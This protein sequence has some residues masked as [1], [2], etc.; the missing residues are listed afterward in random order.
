MNSVDR[1]RSTVLF[2][3]TEVPFVIVD[4]QGE[5]MLFMRNY[6]GVKVTS[7]EWF[8]SYLTSRN[9][10]FCVKSIY[11]KE[12]DFQIFVQQGSIKTSVLLFQGT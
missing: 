6:V 12:M 4:V 3:E 1:I 7:P 2:F 5:M 9:L 8:H 11:S 10:V